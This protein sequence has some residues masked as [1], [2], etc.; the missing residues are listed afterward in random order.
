VTAIARSAVVVSAAIILLAGAVSYLY[1]IVKTPPI[2]LI[3]PMLALFAGYTLVWWLDRRLRT[4]GQSAP[5]ES[6]QSHT[7]RDTP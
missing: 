1:V 7:P 2:F 6:A 5:K 3:G 4:G